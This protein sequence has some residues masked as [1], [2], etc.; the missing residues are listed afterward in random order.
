MKKE[1]QQQKQ[2]NTVFGDFFIARIRNIRYIS[3]IDLKLQKG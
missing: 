1:K 2:E 3:W